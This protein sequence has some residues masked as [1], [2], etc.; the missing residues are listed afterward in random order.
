MLGQVGDAVLPGDP[1]Q[2]SL[3]AQRLGQQVDDVDVV[4]LRLHVGAGRGEGR[5]ILED[6]DLEH[7]RLD[8]VVQLVGCGR[9]RRQNQ[10]ER[11]NHAG[12]EGKTPR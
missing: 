5:E 1:D 3:D 2:L 8:D 9:A 11:Q 10:G 6:A 12:R 4:A 7:A